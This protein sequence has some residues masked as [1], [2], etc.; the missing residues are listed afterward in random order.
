[1]Y[2]DNRK[3]EGCAIFTPPSPPSLAEEYTI[4]YPSIVQ[5]ILCPLS[6][7]EGLLI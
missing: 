2:W 5:L 4:V 3:R 7:R 6:I 1:M